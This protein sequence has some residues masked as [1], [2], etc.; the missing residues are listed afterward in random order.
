MVFDISTFPTLV[1]LPVVK[2]YFLNMGMFQQIPRVRD[3]K[4]FFSNVTDFSV[5]L[6]RFAIYIYVYPSEASPKKVMFKT[7]QEGTLIANPV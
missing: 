5:G 2:K 3:E 4:S 1:V 6:T 7:S